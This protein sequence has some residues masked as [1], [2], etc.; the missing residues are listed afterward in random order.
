M[1]GNTDAARVRH[2][3]L[4][5]LETIN[6]YE[7]F[8]KAAGSE[9]LKQFF[10]H[11][12]DEEKEHVAEVTMILRKLDAKQ[13]ADFQKIYGTEHFKTGAP[14]AAATPPPA[15]AKPS[16]IPEDLPLPADPRKLL[17]ALPFPGNISASQFTVGPLKRRR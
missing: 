9:E 4:R 12:A 14:T 11:L 6:T 13:E 3:L 10:L 2:V 15:P 1:E 5:E 16:A 8:A 17:Y 7:E